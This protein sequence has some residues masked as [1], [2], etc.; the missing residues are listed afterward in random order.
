M[1]TFKVLSIWELKHKLQQSTIMN[2][3]PNHPMNQ[4]KQWHIVAKSNISIWGYPREIFMSINQI[5]D[6]IV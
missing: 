5:G 6:G 1:I 4:H 3:I 2:L